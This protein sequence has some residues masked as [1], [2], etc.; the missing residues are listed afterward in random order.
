MK[1]ICYCILLLFVLSPLF[2]FAQ[3]ER[4]N[5][6]HFGKYAGLDFNQSPPQAI[7]VGQL[8]TGE[9]CA[10]IADKSGNLLFYTDGITIWNANHDT[11]ANGDNLQGSFNSA[12]SALIV[13]VAP[14]LQIHMRR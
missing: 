13:P 8:Y 5:I 12:Q 6:W 14:G 7:T 11:I 1:N 2:V 4:T 3:K 9:G 10:S